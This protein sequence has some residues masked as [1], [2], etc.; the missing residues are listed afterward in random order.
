MDLVSAIPVARSCRCMTRCDGSGI[1]HILTRHEQGAVFAAEGYARAHR[2]CRRC[3]RYQRSRARPTWLPASPTPRWIQFRWSASP[4]RCGP[5]LI[6]TDAFQETD[7]FGMTLSLTKWSRLVRT[8]EE[9]PARDRG[10]FLL[11]AQ[12]ASRPG[13]DRYSRRPA[14]GEA[15][16]SAGPVNS[17][18]HP[19]AAE[20]KR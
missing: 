20:A 17:Y 2:K 15:R 8:I 9:I 19:R 3:H 7:V 5:P 13:D 10:G 12:R 4:G 14:E 6:G 1:R 11:G 18:P 16:N